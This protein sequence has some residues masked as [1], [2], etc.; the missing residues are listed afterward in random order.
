MD[1]SF[2]HGPGS[3]GSKTEADAIIGKVS[4]DRGIEVV[5]RMMKQPGAG[6]GAGFISDHKNFIKIEKLTLMNAKV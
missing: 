6:K 1:N 4:D 3:Q 5:K 2:N